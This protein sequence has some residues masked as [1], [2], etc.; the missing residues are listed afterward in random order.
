ML[1][2]PS[3][4]LRLPLAISGLSPMANKTWLGSSVFEAHAEPLE[5]SIPSMSK[6]RTMASPSM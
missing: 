4:I 2:L 6:P 1:Y 3:E 5:A